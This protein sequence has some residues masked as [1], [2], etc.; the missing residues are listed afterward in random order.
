MR[1]IDIQ[2]KAKL[3][4]VYEERIQSLLD[5]GYKIRHRTNFRTFEV[6]RMHHMA[7]GNDIVI[8]AD[9]VDYEIVQKTNQLVTHR[10][11]F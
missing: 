8:F 9:L 10:E 7:N 1:A 11:T 6:C 3:L 4:A 5:D 2:R